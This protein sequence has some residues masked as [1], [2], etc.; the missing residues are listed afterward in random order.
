MTSYFELDD[1]LH[2]Q[3]ATEVNKVEETFNVSLYTQLVIMLLNMECCTQAE[4]IVV[5]ALEVKFMCNT[6]EDHHTTT[7]HIY[8]L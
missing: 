7:K 4:E 2:I 8:T 1:V 6:S 5:I 3:R